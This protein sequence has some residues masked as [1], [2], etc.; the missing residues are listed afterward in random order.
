MRWG[1]AIVWM[2][3][4]ASRGVAGE[5]ES[6]FG[7]ANPHPE[8]GGGWPMSADDGEAEAEVAQRELA[9][10]SGRQRLEVPPESPAAETL[11]A[12]ERVSATSETEN[13]SSCGSETVQ[14][15]DSSVH[16]ASELDDEME[17]FGGL[18]E[19][20]KTVVHWLDNLG[21][22]EYWPH[23][24]EHELCDMVGA[25]H[26]RAASCSRSKRALALNDQSSQPTS[27]AQEAVLH[28]TASELREIGCKPGHIKKFMK[29]LM[30]LQTIVLTKNEAA[31]REWVYSLRPR[32]G[33][34][35][36]VPAPVR[37]LRAP[38]IRERGQ[39]YVS[40]RTLRRQGRMSD[41]LNA[42]HERHPS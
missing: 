7:A 28:V 31:V 5:G 29:R 2:G 6:T 3:C 26:A 16:S 11:R 24:F 22:L 14:F 38:S 12:V 9:A 17:G 33:A 41:E 10:V 30:D 32:R 4:G 36:S 1:G 15:S 42:I 34:D 20:Q 39:H 8:Q 23:F 19:N 25:I 35:G 40:L 27:R 21:M 13:I 37:K 18:D